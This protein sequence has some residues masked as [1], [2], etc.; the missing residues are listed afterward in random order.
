MVGKSAYKTTSDKER[1][2]LSKN[3]IGCIPCLLM[4][5]P[6][7]HADYHH[8]IE[9][10]KRKSHSWGYPSCVYHHR[11]ER[12]PNMTGREHEKKYGPSYF[13]QRKRFREFFGGERNLVM[14]TDL[15][16]ELA[17]AYGWE[18]LNPPAEVVEYLQTYWR[19]LGGQHP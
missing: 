15:A 17:K 6:G 18:E 8:V 3:M 1:I 7:R 16:V 4:G 5:H 9:G 12:D 10:G 13:D 14:V 19:K 2:E 11:G